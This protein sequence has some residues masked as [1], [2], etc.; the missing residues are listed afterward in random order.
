MQK[1]PY[2]FFVRT[3]YPAPLAHLP[4]NV[5]SVERQL[6]KLDPVNRFYRQVE[7]VCYLL[8]AF[9]GIFA[10]LYSISEFLR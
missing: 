4:L 3:W 10:V 7:T 9:S 1:S 8:L 5:G 6:W 2:V